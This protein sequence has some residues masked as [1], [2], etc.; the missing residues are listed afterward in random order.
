MDYIKKFKPMACVSAVIILAGL[1]VGIFT[2]G[3]NIG[4]DFSGGTELTVDLKADYDMRIITDALTANNA[5]GAQTVR[6][7]SNASKQNEVI[8]RMKKSISNI[9]QHKSSIC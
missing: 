2:G 1:V 8:I 6:S 3:L 9:P 7:G 4:V 5:V